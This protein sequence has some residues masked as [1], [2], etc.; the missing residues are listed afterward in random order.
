ME[1]ENTNEKSY[2]SIV[3]HYC[4]VDTF[5]S[6]ISH[7]TLRASNIRKS[8]DYHEVISCM[9]NFQ[10]AMRNALRKYHKTFPYDS[11]FQQFYYID[12]CTAID[13]DALIE[14]AID[15]ES[16]TYYCVCFSEAKDLLSQWR[17]YAGDGTG[18]AIGFRESFLRAPTDFCHY[19]YASIEY[20]LFSVR[21]DLEKYIF[22]RFE[23]ARNYLGDRLTASDYSNVLFQVINAMVY[24]AIFYKDS[25][26]QE[27]KERRLVYYPFGNIRNL[28]ISHKARDISEHQLY[29][30]RMSE[31]F[32]SHTKLAQ[33]ER[34]PL[35]FS[36]RNGQITSY[37]DFNFTQCLPWLIPEI[38]LG[39]KNTM[40][41]LDLRLFLHSHGID[42]SYTKILHSASAYR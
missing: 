24:N 30:D 36:N 1:L 28:N 12:D 32:N 4:S 3:Y 42:L 13:T 26:F 11:E 23:I 27:E 18:V 16:C 7:K 22:H 37:V 39:P 31:L 17:G 6:I 41:D 14:K 5:M 2:N 20:D 9:G 40:D 10:I 21:A 29:Y 25:S 34:M 15:N 38:I 8:N 35:S 33:L 19:K